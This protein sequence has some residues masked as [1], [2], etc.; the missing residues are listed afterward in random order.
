MESNMHYLTTEQL[1]AV[2]RIVSSL[3]AVQDIDYTAGKCAELMTQLGPLETLNGVTS[4]LTTVAAQ[5]M[6]GPEGTDEDYEATLKRLGNDDISINDLLMTFYR[7]L[8]HSIVLKLDTADLNR[9]VAQME[10]HVHA[11]AN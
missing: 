1:A 2:D 9:I 5:V 7:C 10:A 4:A 3:L 6:T 8:L 11:T